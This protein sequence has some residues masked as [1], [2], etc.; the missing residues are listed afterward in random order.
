MGENYGKNADYIEG[1]DVVTFLEEALE[2]LQQKQSRAV[3]FAAMRDAS[4]IQEA[5]AIGWKHEPEQMMKYG[6]TMMKNLTTRKGGYDTKR[7]EMTDFERSPLD[8][9]TPVVLPGRSGMGKTNFLK[10]H[11]KYPL[12]V[13]TLDG[14]K[15]IVPGTTDLI[16]FDDMNF[17]AGTREQPGLNLTAEQIIA[18][19]DINERTTLKTRPNHKGDDVELPAGMKRVFSTNIDLEGM[20]IDETEQ[21]TDINGN[22]LHIFPKGAN[23][24]QTKAIRRRYKLE[25]YVE[26]PLFNIKKIRIPASCD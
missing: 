3:T 6:H 20:W 25:N 14:L 21:Q 17:G 8:L 23:F 7:F 11:G 15:K 9:T 16:I 18:L 13:K 24:E 10:A 22:I 5:N 12:V 2:T 1:G 26:Q 19:L 4:T